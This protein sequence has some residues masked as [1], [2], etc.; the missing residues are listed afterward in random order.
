MNGTPT[1]DEESTPRRTV[2][3]DAINCNHV[4]AACPDCPFSRSVTPGALGGSHPF[5]YL[6]QA[7][8][9]FV[10]PCHKHCDFADPDWK[11]KAINTPQCAGA[12]IFRANIGV[13]DLLPEQIHKMSPNHE[14]VFSSPEEFLMHHAGVSREA[15]SRIM[16]HHPLA[17]MLAEQLRRQSTIHFV[18]SQNE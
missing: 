4:K 13:A 6:G 18:K 14:T 3:F 17:S 12:A 11:A 1:I 2:Q 7:A 8:G 5:V 9:P 16:R 10:L 15:A